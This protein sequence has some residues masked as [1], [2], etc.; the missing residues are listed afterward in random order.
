MKQI[1]ASM[2]LLLLAGCATGE[3]SV[4]GRTRIEFQGTIIDITEGVLAA[5][6]DIYHSDAEPRTYVSASKFYAKDGPSIYLHM[7]QWYD[8]PDLTTDGCGNRVER[9]HAEFSTIRFDASRSIDAAFAC[10]GMRGRL[11]HT[12]P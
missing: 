10:A 7:Q 8:T 3:R 11:V 4:G 9:T 1:L 12:M 2:S 6:N 5:G